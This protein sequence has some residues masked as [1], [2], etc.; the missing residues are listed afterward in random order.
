MTRASS[1]FAFTDY[2]EFLKAAYDAEKGANR[3]FSH[4][5]IMTKVGASST[6]W[7]SDVVKGRITLN[8]AFAIRLANLFALG[9]KDEEYFLAL[10]DYGQA[11]SSEE[12]S[13]ALERVVSF[14]EPKADVVGKDK[15]EYYSRW[16]YAAIREILFIHPFK[17]DYAEL[18]RKLSPAITAGQAKRAVSLLKR[19]EFVAQD[20]TGRIRPV[21]AIVKKDSEVKSDNLANFLRANMELGIEAISRYDKADRDISALTLALSPQ[22]FKTA[23]EEIRVLR[24]RLLALSENPHPDKRVFQCNFQVFPVTEA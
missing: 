21:Q 8:Q 23:R 7:F 1:I 13:R 15:F 3:L 14:R 16:Y 19:L 12:K 6:G 24:K 2:R 9:S 10:V 5:F 4:R 11:G 18:A 22:D 20:E 17:G